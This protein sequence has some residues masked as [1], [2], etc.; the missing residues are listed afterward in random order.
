MFGKNPQMTPLQLRKQLLLAESELNR[1]QLVGDMTALTADLRALADRAKS[2]GLI[3]ASVAALVA[4]LA[5][6]RR[7]QSASAAAKPPWFQ[8]FL[9]GAGLLSNLW[10]AFRPK[11][12]GQR[13]A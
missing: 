1:A 7:R 9:K 4:G 13:E 2:I 10:K 8:T 6:F 3:T 5:A 11:E 12:S